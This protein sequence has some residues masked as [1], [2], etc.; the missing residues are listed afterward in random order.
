MKKAIKSLKEGK[1]LLLKELFLDL[2]FTY[3]RIRA[4][5][6]Q[7][8][9]V[10]PWGGSMWAFLQTLKKDGPQ[11]IPQYA[12]SRPTSRQNVLRMSNEA[13]K[14]GLI[15]F[16]ENPAHKRSKLLVLTTKGEKY[17]KKM[18]K[19]ILALTERLA[20]KFTKNEIEITLSVLGRLRDEMD[21]ELKSRH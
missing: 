8:G 15:D 14:A 19:D 12:R 4:V 5:G 1:G 20:G 21:E 17:Y 10:S 16:L 7:I 3:F 9:F 11:T 2:A 13:S 6:V 18:D